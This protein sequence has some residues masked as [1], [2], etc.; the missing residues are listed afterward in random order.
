MLALM[1]PQQMAPVE[2][3]GIQASFHRPDIHVVVIAAAMLDLQDARAFQDGSPTWLD[4]SPYRGLL[5]L[6]CP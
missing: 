5:A 3:K 4:I 1:T 2:G 6:F